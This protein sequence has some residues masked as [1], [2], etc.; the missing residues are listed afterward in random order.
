MR[1]GDDGEHDRRTRRRLGGST[2]SPSDS[3]TTLVRRGRLRGGLEARERL[4]GRSIAGEV[5]EHWRL[6]GGVGE[7]LS[8][9]GDERESFGDEGNDEKRT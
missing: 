3:P 6:V 2:V 9:V 8:N 1:T 7:G 4:D 5:G